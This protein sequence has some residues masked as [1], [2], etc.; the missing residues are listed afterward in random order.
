MSGLIN[1]FK[2][3]FFCETAANTV[4]GIAQIRENNIFVEDLTSS[5]LK[6][7]ANSEMY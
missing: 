3:L 5:R 4:I 7:I 2:K 6:N 1:L